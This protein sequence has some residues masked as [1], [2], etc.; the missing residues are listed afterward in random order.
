ME[1]VPKDKVDVKNSPL[2]TNIS[3]ITKFT[4]EL[5]NYEDY[6]KFLVVRNPYDRVL[7]SYYE[8]I[9]PENKYGITT[10]KHF[11]KFIETME[12]KWRP[13][14][15]HFMPIV[16]MV[17]PLGI[18]TKIYKLED[19]LFEVLPKDLDL[20][21]E[22]DIKFSSSKNN[23]V[24]ISKEDLYEFCKVIKKVYKDDLIEFNYDI[25]DSQYLKRM[26]YEEV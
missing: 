11:L 1:V 14:H 8:Y 13:E 22:K 25:K 4:K 24:P 9:T 15:D 5:F 23:Y 21:F 2:H 10:F 3:R 20:E 19:N 26:E 12:G 16:D 18:Y 17:L 6:F 7:S